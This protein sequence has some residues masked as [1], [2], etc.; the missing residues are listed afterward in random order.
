MCSYTLARCYQQD[1]D[2]GPWPPYYTQKNTCFY[3]VAA[4]LEIPP[5]WVTCVSI[6]MYVSVSTLSKKCIHP[7]QT[8]QSSACWFLSNTIWYS[9]VYKHTH[10]HTRTHKYRNTHGA[11]WSTLWLGL[12]TIGT[13][14]GLSDFLFSCHLLHH[15]LTHTGSHYSQKSIEIGQRQ[16]KRFPKSGSNQV[17]IINMMP[18]VISS[19]FLSFFLFCWR[20]DLMF[21][22]CDKN[23]HMKKDSFAPDEDV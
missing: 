13:T 14:K 17:L 2:T 12:I 23:N 15:S 9:L 8:A 5:T 10:T 7:A 22:S 16:L 1:I 6:C 11:C 19:F 3:T 21:Y 4:T 18:S 20:L